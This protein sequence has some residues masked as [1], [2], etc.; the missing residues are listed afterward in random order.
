VPASVGWRGTG[1]PLAGCVV[2]WQ[3]PKQGFPSEATK[4]IVDIDLDE[5][6]A[7]DPSHR[8][9]HHRQTD[10]I[11]IAAQVQVN[12]YHGTGTMVAYTVQIY[13]CRRELGFAAERRYLHR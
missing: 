2:G 10:R 8:E 11:K 12:K 9:Y 3:Q 13:R 1:A 4:A 7:R 5:L 6:P